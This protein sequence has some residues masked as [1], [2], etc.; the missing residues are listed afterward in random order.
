MTE[1]TEADFAGRSYARVYSVLGKK[2][3]HRF[4]VAAV[5]AAGGRVLYASAPARTPVYLGVQDSRGDRLGL[6]IYPFRMTRKATVNR[7]ADEVRGQIRYG[8][9][10]TWKVDHP[11]GTDIA[12]V[13]ITLV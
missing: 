12:G 3:I 7:P 5:E 6:L 1:P 2:D 4:L 10:D 11:L 9:E 8:G 13:D